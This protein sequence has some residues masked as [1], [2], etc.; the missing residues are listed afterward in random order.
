MGALVKFPSQISGRRMV[1]PLKAPEA[2]VP[3]DGTELQ[4][5]TQLLAE[6]RGRGVPGVMKDQV[7]Q[8]AGPPHIQNVLSH[9]IRIYGEDLFISGFS[10]TKMSYSVHHLRISIHTG[11]L[12]RS[13]VQILALSKQH[14][15]LRE[16]P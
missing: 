3:G 6:F 13:Q 5:V 4:H 1:V 10:M 14:Y 9:G 15:L 12:S 16:G 8:P 7:L 11:S 2:A